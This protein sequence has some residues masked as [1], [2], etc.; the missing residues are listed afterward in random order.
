MTDT[1]ARRAPLLAANCR[2][3][4]NLFLSECG[5]DFCFVLSCQMK[6]PR[7]GTDVDV[8]ADDVDVNVAAVKSTSGPSKRIETRQV[9]IT[10]E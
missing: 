2:G 10:P 3:L 8:D 4:F 6:S 9:P 1:D 7:V 5:K